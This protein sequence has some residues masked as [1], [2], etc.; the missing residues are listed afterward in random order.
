MKFNKIQEFFPQRS[1]VKMTGLAL[2][3]FVITLMLMACAGRKAA[4]KQSVRQNIRPEVQALEL[5]KK[6]PDI[7]YGEGI[8]P[9]LDNDMGGALET[10][11]KRA[12]RDLSRKIQVNVEE[13]ISKI[14]QSDMSGSTE[15]IREQFT[16]KVRTY[17][18]SVLTN[19]KDLRAINYPAPGNI[20]V[21]VYMSRAEYRQKVNE[22]LKSKK[23][24]VRTAAQNGDQ[25]FLRNE[26]MIAATNWARAYEQLQNFFGDL[27]VQDDLN[28]DG[29]PDDVREY[30]QQKMSQLFGNMELSF[31]LDQITY[32]ANGTLTKRPM[33]QARFRHQTG[34]DKAV[35]NLPLKVEFISG[36]GQVLGRVMT[37]KYGVAELSLKVDASY[38][39]TE[40]AVG[41]DQQSIPGLNYFTLPQLSEARLTINKIKTVALAVLFNNNGRRSSPEALNNEIKN[42][43]LN[44]GY[45]TMNFSTSGGQVS[46]SDLARATQAN[47]D[48]L[49]FVAIRANGGS[50]VGG[51]ANMFAST[52]SGHVSLYRLPRGDE[53]AAERLPSV[54]GFGVS[55][56][57]AGWDG[58]GKVK[59][60]VIK[61]AQK[62]IESIP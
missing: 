32:D 43:L 39:Q 20:T 51:Y 55:A 41:I 60:A 26:F 61:K 24:A 9:I 35:A 57:V 42:L 59:N 5:K 40:I 46:Q 45:L 52:V 27:P 38:P 44:K 34:A 49:L 19:T 22:D 1:D 4:Q 29:R 13:T 7:Y 16:Q 23:A 47:A 21:L 30:L 2:F 12:L 25:A 17:T 33:V 31:L 14:T 56:D 18:N 48:Y 50:T 28:G 37:N 53:I 62:I 15:N 8:A 11:K 36:K 6:D 54:K 3:I 10:A 58:Y